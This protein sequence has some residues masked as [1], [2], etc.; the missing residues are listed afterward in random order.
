[1]S[2]GTELLV[3]RGE[4]DASDEPLDATIAG[5]AAETLAYPLAYGYSL[6]GEVVGVGR[7]APAALVGKLCFAFAPHAAAAFVPADGLMAVPSDVGAADAAFLPAAETAVS[8][9]HDAH[10]RLGETVA[11]FGQ[12]VIGL[13]V[14]AALAAMGIRVHAVDLDPARRDLARRLGAAVASGPEGAPRR[15]ADVAIECSGS[16]KALQAAIDAAIDHGT[17]VIASWY[18]RKPVAL[19]LGMHARAAPAAAA[20]L[21]P[22]GRGP[23]L[24]LSTHH[25]TP[26]LRRRLAHL[27]SLPLPPSWAGTRFHRSHIK[28]IASQVSAVPGGIADT[29]SKARRF[30]AAW[31]LIRRVRPATCLVSVTLPLRRAAEGYARLEAAKAVVVMLSYDEAREEE[32]A[33][34]GAALLGA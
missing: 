2:S 30:G 17:V 21:Q 27:N 1:V 13:L 15:A 6:V 19:T 11:V 9:V 7:G 5:L 20:C 23:Q 12:G 33:T 31:D 28:L 24:H 34:Q 32:E 25:C 14:T 26:R 10:P 8:L 18:G 29:W 4:L 16:P 22:P 3:W